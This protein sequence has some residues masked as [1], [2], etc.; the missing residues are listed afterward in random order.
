MTVLEQF[1][2]A[3]RSDKYQ[4]GI[5]QLRSGDCFCA[6]GVL[7]DVVDPAGWDERKS[8]TRTHHGH[9]IF[10]EKR[11]CDA[12][13]LSL[14]VLTQVMKWNDDVRLSLPEIAERIEAA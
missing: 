4:Q 10:P 6:L 13:G 5:G 8:W 11:V 2:A 7:C 14:D 1:L 12:V 3:L 9:A